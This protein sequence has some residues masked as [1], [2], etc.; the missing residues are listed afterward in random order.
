MATSSVQLGVTAARDGAGLH[1][2]L[3]S[4]SVAFGYVGLGA[5]AAQAVRERQVVENELLDTRSGAT[6]FP[7]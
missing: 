1:A 2:L 4:I 7:W 3:R 5:E 6:L